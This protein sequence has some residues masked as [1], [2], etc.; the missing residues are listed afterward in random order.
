MDL[1][2]LNNRIR[3]C[4]IR[5]R[6][7]SHEL[8]DKMQDVWV[9]MIRSGHMAKFDE[10]KGSIGNHVFVVCRSVCYNHFR[11]SSK[12]TY[13]D[14]NQMPLLETA[15]E[16]ENGLRG[17][18]VLEL[19]DLDP[20]NTASSRLEM[21]EALKK[22]RTKLSQR[23]LWSKSTNVTAI[24]SFGMAVENNLWQLAL[25]LHIDGLTVEEVADNL[26]VSVGSVRNWS[27][28]LKKAA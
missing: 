26:K 14:F 19:M 24:E 17:I 28:R 25:W 8:E 7:P 2:E 15:P 4:L 16:E 22:I 9:K 5:L 12:R 27:S 6:C 1:N 10:V 18:K 20:T 23:H 13:G 3:S 11:D 21:S